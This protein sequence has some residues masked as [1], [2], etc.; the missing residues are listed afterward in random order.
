MLAMFMFLPIALLLHKV[1]N[2]RIAGY[3]DDVVRSYRWGFFLR[4]WTEVYLEVLTA[5]ML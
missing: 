1:K 5:S 4:G 3:F 2:H